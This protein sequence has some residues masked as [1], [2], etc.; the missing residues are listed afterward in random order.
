MRTRAAVVVRVEIRAL[1]LGLASATALVAEVGR[2]RDYPPR[3][4]SRRV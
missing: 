4:R 3:C 1:L 2:A